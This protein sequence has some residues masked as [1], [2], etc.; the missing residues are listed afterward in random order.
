MIQNQT[1]D[2]QFKLVS[3]GYVAEN[4]SRTTDQVEVSLTELHPYID[5]ELTSSVSQDSVSGTDADGN[6]QT[7]TVIMANTVLA[8]WMGDNTNRCSA[9]DV[10]RGE[11]VQIYQFGD[12]DQYFWSTF[13][14]PGTPNVRKKET[15][16]HAYNNSTDE[17]QNEATPDNS[18]F[19]EINTHEKHATFKTNKSDGEPFAYT[20]Q[21]DAKR[22]NVVVADDAGTYFQMDSGNQHIQLVTAGGGIVEVNKND[23]TITCGNITVNA[24]G[25]ITFNG[26]NGKVTIPNTAWTGGIGLSGDM[27]SSGGSYTF[28]GPV[29][30]NDALTNKG[31][32]VGAEHSHKGVQPGG[33]NTGDV[34]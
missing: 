14:P 17:T 25:T 26:A 28:N 12:T 19:S 33:G 6:A 16:V 24:S 7:F 8:R 11:K 23:V 20:L 13:N 4:K 29:A 30:T 3:I 21:V 9:P 34:N 5:G 1:K 32:N 18:W 10:R 22:G 2:S 27:E 15:V 31:K